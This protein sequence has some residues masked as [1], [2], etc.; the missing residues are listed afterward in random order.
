MWGNRTPYEV[1]KPYRIRNEQQTNDQR[2]EEDALLTY[3]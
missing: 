2:N 1:G 3:R